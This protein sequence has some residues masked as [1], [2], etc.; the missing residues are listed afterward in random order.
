MKLAHGDVYPIVQAQASRPV[1][2]K[3]G[4]YCSRQ[5]AAD[6]T[7]PRPAV[8]GCV[9][10]GR[11]SGTAKSR[12]KETSPVFVTIDAVRVDTSSHSMAVKGFFGSTSSRSVNA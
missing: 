10:F 11:W 3:V 2:V 7:A 1:V 5:P 6:P 9:C 4:C 12:T 8:C